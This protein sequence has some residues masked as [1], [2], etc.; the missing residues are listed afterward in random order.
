MEELNL[1]ILTTNRN[2]NIILSFI[3]EIESNNELKLMNDEVMVVPPNYN[4]DLERI[5]EYDWIPVTNINDV[6]E[7]G[8]L[9]PSRSFSCY[10]KIN[11]EKIRSIII[12]FTVD[13]HLILGLSLG[14]SDENYEYSKKLLSSLFIKYNGISGGIFIEQFPALS[15]D[16]FEKYLKENSLF[17][18]D[19]SSFME[20][21]L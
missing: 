12:G 7:L 10:L 1:Y 21:K 15:K 13:S 14:N 17:K 6:I 20:E 18:L 5:E 19:Q 2:K 16:L 3:S 8:S 4:G 9:N 11:N